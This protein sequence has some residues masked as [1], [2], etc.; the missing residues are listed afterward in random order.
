MTKQKE[1]QEEEQQQQD[2]AEPVTQEDEPVASTS[3]QEEATETEVNTPSQVTHQEQTLVSESKTPGTGIEIQRRQLLL[4][5]LGATA[6]LVGLSAWLWY[7]TSPNTDQ[8]K[9]IKG[10]EPLIPRWNNAALQAIRELQP[11]VP[12]AARALAIV[13]TCM[14]DAWTAY[15]SAA[16]STRPETHLKRPTTEHTLANKS[17]A[18]SFAAYRALVDLFPTRQTLFQQIMTHLGYNA[19]NASINPK[20]PAGI[21]NRAALA[22]L[23][24]RHR[25]GANQTG[26]LHPQAYSD[27]TKYQPL[28]SPDML[29]DPNHWQP[30]ALSNGHTSTPQTFIGAQWADVMPFALS[31]AAQFLPNTGPAHYPSSLYTQQ[32]QEILQY[33]ADLTDEHK[34]IAEYWTNGPNK[35]QPAGHWSLIAQFISQRDGHNLDQNVKMFFALTNALLDASIACWAVKRAYD[36]PYPL[37][38]IRYLFRNKLV[39]AWAGPGKSHQWIEGA[40]WQ[41]YQPESQ[42]TPPY[43]EYCSE[44]STFSAAAA[45][46]LRHFTG[47]DQLGMS[48]TC[49]AYSSPIDPNIP[50]NDITLTWRTLSQAADQAGLSQRYSGIHFPQGDLDGRVLGRQVGRLVWQKVMSYIGSL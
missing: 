17:Q 36:S 28:N 25:D 42:M 38:A 49:P 10:G 13:H 41:P 19:A 16:S 12:I 14:F 48:Y 45:E 37:T 39:L 47:S 33:S 7:E 31:S 6:T 43:P 46:I 24:F 5:G 1:E 4:A 21:G 22:V 18:I 9:Q 35:E 29:K 34:V 44:H 50:V 8:V 30:L 11:A 26:N 23:A 2:D 15:D 20:T 32:A 40:Y 3:P 27:Y